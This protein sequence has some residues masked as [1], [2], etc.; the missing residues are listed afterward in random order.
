MGIEPT[1]DLV[2][3]HTGFEDQ[4]RHQAASHLRKNRAHCHRSV[5]SASIPLSREELMIKF[6]YRRLPQYP[7][8]FSPSEER[9]RLSALET[10]DLALPQYVFDG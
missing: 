6:N 3:S 8:Q 2:E 7:N 4:E 5:S 1:W 10:P 9:F